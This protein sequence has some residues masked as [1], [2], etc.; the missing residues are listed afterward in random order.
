M[1]L[2]ALGMMSGTSLDGID[3]A[4]LRTDGQRI[5]GFGPWRSTPYR[6]TLREALRAASKASLGGATG[7]GGLARDVTAAHASVVNDLLKEEG[8]TSSEIDIIGFHGQTILH[9]P[10]E[11]RTVQIGEG[12]ALAA[13]TRIDVVCDFRSADM[14]AGGQGAP[15]APLYHAARAA[16]LPRPLAVLNIGGIANVTYLSADGPPT[17][18]DTGPGNCLLD[19]WVAARAGQTMDRDGMLAGAGTVAGGVLSALMAHPYFDASP[20]KSLDRGDFSLGPA[21]G[22]SIA[23]GAATLAAF[24]ARAVALAAATF[25]APPGRWLVS[26]GGRRN[27]ALMAALRQALAAPV[28]AVEAVGWRGDA[29]EAEA[30]AFLAVRAL[31]GLPLSLPSTTGVARPTTGGALHRFERAGGR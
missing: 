31:R 2:C 22:L 10:A 4:I 17:A 20:P 1:E 15:L 23:D 8:L 21:A 13:G 5:S 25:P 12:A 9:R 16:D 6:A 11:G 24:T 14:A 26:G 3:A 18:F 28:D 27:P 29:L 7:L 30:F 19:D